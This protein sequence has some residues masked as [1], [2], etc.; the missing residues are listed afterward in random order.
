MKNFMM[1]GWGAVM[2]REM[3]PQIMRMLEYAYMPIQHQ[4]H[5]PPLYIQDWDPS[6]I[7]IQPV[8][9]NPNPNPNPQY[10]PFAGIPRRIGDDAIVVHPTGINPVPLPKPMQ[11]AMQP[12]P[13]KASE[14]KHP[15]P[16]TPK[17]RQIQAKPTSIP[18]PPPILGRWA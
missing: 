16:I 17:F 11:Q 15:K 9:P 7:A 13:A 5:Q 18:P 10:Q 12:P 14:D 2:I 1:G 8:M 4:H 3:T 6:H